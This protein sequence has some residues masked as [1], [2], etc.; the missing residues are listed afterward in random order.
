MNLKRTTDTK[1]QKGA[2]G[3]GDFYNIEFLHANF[4]DIYGFFVQAA[5]RY[6]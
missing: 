3:P 6:S 2:V 4:S 5:Q 1:E